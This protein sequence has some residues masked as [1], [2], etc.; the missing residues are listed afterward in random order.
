MRCFG[1]IAQMEAFDAFL[2]KAIGVCDQLVLAQMLHPRN[3]KK[4]FNDTPFIGG[5]REHAPAI[6]A[7]AATFV[8]EL[9]EDL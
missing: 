7:V 8:S 3:D 4:V 5:I 2:D 1:L 9:L 6:S